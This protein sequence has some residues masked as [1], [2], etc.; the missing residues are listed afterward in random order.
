M[1]YGPVPMHGNGDHAP[2]TRRERTDRTL[3]RRVV[4]PLA[5]LVTLTM[6]ASAL[7]VAV[8]APDAQAAK[9]AGATIAGKVRAAGSPVRNVDVLPYRWDTSAGKW[10]R[11][12]TS[13]ATTDATGKYQLRGLPAG[14]YHLLVLPSERQPYAPVW[15]GAAVDWNHDP[16]LGFDP[17][18]VADGRIRGTEIRVAAGKK[19]T[20]HHV[21]LTPIGRIGSASTSKDPLGDHPVIDLRYHAR[22]DANATGA[23]TTLTW[24]RPGQLRVPLLE[25]GTH[26]FFSRT[27]AGPGQPEEDW[28]ETVVDVP[29]SADI[30]AQFPGQAALHARTL[31]MDYT[32]VPGTPL[33]GTVARTTAANLVNWTYPSGKLTTGLRWLRDGVPIPGATG[34]TYTITA[35]DV[36]KLLQ[37]EATATR[38]GYTTGVVRSEARLVRETPRTAINMTLNR[39]K[40]R[41]GQT[42]KVTVDVTVTL[43]NGEDP[44]GYGVLIHQGCSEEHPYQDECFGWGEYATQL[45]PTTWRLQLPA[46]IPIQDRIYAEFLPKAHYAWAETSL[47]LRIKPQPSKVKLTLAKKQVRRGASATAKVAITAPH[48]RRTDIRG[49]LV[50]KAGSSTIGKTKLRPMGGKKGERVAARKAVLRLDPVYRTGKIKLRAI[51]KPEKV[52]RSLPSNNAKVL[53]GDSGAKRGVSK[54]VT[55]RVR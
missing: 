41:Y 34:A 10:I 3:L 4:L 24:Q 27:S 54:K 42:D 36:G 37:S 49:T 46:R 22:N 39:S 7:T 23:P 52:K 48:N 31:V 45:T 20:G 33:V 2:L 25:T 43:D 5:A 1:G 12:Y 9:P 19:L 29:A 28:I 18:D 13:E 6:A 21:A 8:G 26:T 17:D 47:P 51:F 11:L 44:Q 30:A 53:R 55:L 14:R 50:V 35:A 38:A 40:V 15:Y 16:R 32:H